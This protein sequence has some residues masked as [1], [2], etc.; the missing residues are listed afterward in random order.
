M[1]PTIP[2]DFEED[3]DREIEQWFSISER[4]G[5]VE[6]YSQALAVR[7]YHDPADYHP[8]SENIASRTPGLIIHEGCGYSLGTLHEFRVTVERDLM[9]P[10]D[11]YYVCFR[12]G[13]VEVSIG[14]PTPVFKY[15]F[16]N[17]YDDDYH[18][19]WDWM[20][21]LRLLGTAAINAELFLLNIL[22]HIKLHSNLQ[23]S[24]SRFW[25]PEDDCD[26][27]PTIPNTAT[28]YRHLEPLQLYYYAIHEA[29]DTSACIRFYR[30]LEFYSFVMKDA[31]VDRLRR[32]VTIGTREFLFQ[33][34]RLLSANDRADICQFLAGLTTPS[35]IDVAQANGIINAADVNILSNSLYDFRNSIVHA[36]Y[37]QRATITVDALLGRPP[38]LITW[39]KILFELA[40]EAMN[41]YGR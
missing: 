36:K 33:V 39:R 34:N 35:I 14:S 11:R 37:E 13:D 4:N 28:V 24:L 29:E 20:Y 41:R 8:D 1:N 30:I 15:I 17:N 40:T 22:T 26:E 10:D 18:G 31:A 6:A 21:T 16:L 38:H 5:I 32:D 7:L 3:R 2:Y 12:L 19:D 9:S 25:W 23:V 27:E